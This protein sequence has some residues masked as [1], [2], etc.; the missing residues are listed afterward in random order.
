MTNDVVYSSQITSEEIKRI[1]D[2]PITKR[3]TKV[4]LLHQDETVAKDISDWVQ[5][6]GSLESNFE[7][8]QSYSTSLTFINQT[9][10]TPVPK[11]GLESL[12][13]WYTDRN[14]E[15][16]TDTE[17]NPYFSTELR[18]QSYSRYVNENLK[19]RFNPMKKYDDFEA[20]AK[21]QITSVIELGSEK[22][23]FS[24]GIYVV[25]DPKMTSGEANNTLSIQLYDKFALLDGT[26][27][28]DGEFEY[29]ILYGTKIRDAIVQLLRLPRNKK[30]EP[31]DFKDIRFP[32]KYKD[33]VLA[34]TIKKTGDN[35][36][37]E[38]IKE[39]VE[40]HGFEVKKYTILPDEPTM[41][42]EEMVYMCDDLKVNLI[43]ITGGTGF[44]I[45][46]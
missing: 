12:Y 37:G 16:Y 38:L 1:I 17:G 32:I 43:L 35:A 24:K 45:R 25:H 22:Y 4:Y 13:T 20:N 41:L 8:G 11:D 15:T 19:L 29:E 18:D 39:I 30:G 5:P 44:S 9:I 42:A 3:Y 2:S 27:S 6:T 14:G 31:F 10:K 28:G 36:I 21:I 7:S 40:S 34:Y 23:E 33:E 26:I 46:D